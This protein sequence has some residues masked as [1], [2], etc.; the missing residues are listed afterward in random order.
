MTDK[1]KLTLTWGTCGD[2]DHWC[3]FLKL[4]LAADLFKDLK[5]V[6][7]IWIGKQ[8]VRLGSGIIKD[9]IA[10][11]RKDKAITAYKNLRVTWAKVNANQ[12]EG[13]EKYLADTLKPAIGDAFPDRT[14][15]PVNLPW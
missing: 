2:D 15:I 12:M 1:K 5:G 13:V 3:D 11:H 14:P 9:R 8:V 10:T 4:N 6:Y 7:I